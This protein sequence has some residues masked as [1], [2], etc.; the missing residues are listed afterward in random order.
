MSS[1]AGWRRGSAAVAEQAGL[2][3]VQQQID[4][5]NARLG[6]T[7]DRMS[8]IAAIERSISQLFRA[9]EDHRED[10]HDIAEDAA[11]R[12][13]EEFLQREA[14]PAGP[15]PELVALEEALAAV[16]DHAARSDQ[17]TQET[18]QAV[19]ETLEEIVNKLADLE[20][21][22]QAVLEERHE[23]AAASAAS[24]AAPRH[25]CRDW[26][27]PDTASESHAWQSA[28][29]HLAVQQR[30]ADERPPRQR[31]AEPSAAE[32]GPAMDFFVEPQAGI[33]EF[34]N[35]DAPQHSHA[36]A[37]DDDYIAAARRAAQAAAQGTRLGMGKLPYG[38][39]NGTKLGDKGAQR[40][41]VLAAAPGTRPEAQAPAGRFGN[42][43]GCG[44]Y[45][46]NASGSRTQAP[47]SGSAPA[48]RRRLRRG[49]A[50]Q[51]QGAST[52]PASERTCKIH[53]RV[54]VRARARPFRR[55]A[56]LTHRPLGNGI[57][58]KGRAQGNDRAWQ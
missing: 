44:G 34:Q 41:L 1:R 47:A 54:R 22:Q 20:A 18:L 38:E 8:A 52:G 46:G 25:W 28:V 12:V 5:M 37:S 43:R 29:Q 11:R 2:D 51:L 48:S 21:G 49:A 42:C 53:R 33:V 3:V 36:P 58:G 45:S 6:A 57:A 35:P 16:R 13:A 19:H 56:L 31:T 26:T 14:Q 4:Q 10:A 32:S 15:S 50:Q 24:N 40:I 23:A 7:E 55:P 9:L 27:A 30:S 39:Q 17:Q